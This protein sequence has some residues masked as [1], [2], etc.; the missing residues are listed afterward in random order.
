M[1]LCIAFINSM[2]FHFNRER[3]P[4]IV[5]RMRSRFIISKC[6]NFSFISP[7]TCHFLFCTK[8]LRHHLQTPFWLSLMP[9]SP[10]PFRP[11]RPITWAF[12]HRHPKTLFATPDAPLADSVIL[13]PAVLAQE[14]CPLQPPFLASAH[15]QSWPGTS[16]PGF[17]LSGGLCSAHSRLAS[18]SRSRMEGFSGVAR[19]AY[20]WAF[21]NSSPRLPL[22][23]TPSIMP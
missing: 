15:Q 21:S 9:I 3:T 19:S 16:R 2:H 10:A 8:L 1:R 4:W 7:N 6:S 22:L 5:R 13:S 18:A 12:H 20:S 11:L 23:I 14:E 17:L